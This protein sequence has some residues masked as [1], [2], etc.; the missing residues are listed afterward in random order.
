MDRAQEL[1]RIKRAAGTTDAPGS[2]FV[3]V[4]KFL[5]TVNNFEVLGQLTS[6]AATLAWGDNTL[7]CLYLNGTLEYTMDPTNPKSLLTATPFG[8]AHRD[9]PFERDIEAIRL[10]EYPLLPSRFSALFGF[11]DRDSCERVAQL[12]GWPLEEV[13]KV[14]VEQHEV[15]ARAHRGNMN[16]ISVLHGLYPASLTRDQLEQAI[17]WYWSGSE[18]LPITTDDARFGTPLWEWLVEGTFHRI[19]EPRGTIQDVLRGG[20]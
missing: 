12:H 18:E 2:L 8:V 10:G 17:R 11:E 16:L 1:N 5:P 7:L 3:S 6:S 13:R 14:R 20:S 15:L 9:D 19:D 4:T